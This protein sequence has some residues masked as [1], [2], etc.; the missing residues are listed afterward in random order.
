M[1]KKDLENSLREQLGDWAS[2]RKIKKYL[3]CGDLYLNQLL[4]GVGYRIQ[5]RSK[6]YYVKDIC[7]ALMDFIVRGLS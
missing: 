3:S 4:N 5:G 2:K 1:T 7:E 6:L